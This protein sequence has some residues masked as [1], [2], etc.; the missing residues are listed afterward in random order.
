MIIFYLEFII[1]LFLQISK[2]L[3]EFVWKL[4]ANDQVK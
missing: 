2:I 4:F 1:A 3:V